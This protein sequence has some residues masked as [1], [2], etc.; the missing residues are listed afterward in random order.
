MSE[1]CLHDN[2]H[3]EGRKWWCDDCGKR[4]TAQDKSDMIG[5]IWNEITPEHYANV[6]QLGEPKEDNQK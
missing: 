1:G 2:T 4:I 6:R 3:N 5:R